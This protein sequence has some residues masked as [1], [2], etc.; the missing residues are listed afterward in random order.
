[1]FAYWQGELGFGEAFWWFENYF[2]F[3]FF[4]IEHPPTNS[5]QAATLRTPF[6]FSFFYK[7]LSFTVFT[8]CAP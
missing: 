3:G 1:M 6:S 5:Q 7:A 8:H 2:S 4:F